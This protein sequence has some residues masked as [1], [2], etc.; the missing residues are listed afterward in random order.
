MIKKVSENFKSPGQR[1]G[2]LHHLNRVTSLTLTLLLGP[3]RSPRTSKTERL[4]EAPAQCGGAK[5]N[6]QAANTTKRDE[7]AKS[8]RPIP[9]AA[10][11]E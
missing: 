6:V 4:R 3:P 10:P 9:P 5:K 8:L 7:K 2:R 11:R 1:W